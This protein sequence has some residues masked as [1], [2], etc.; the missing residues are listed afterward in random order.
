MKKSQT[1]FWDQD[2]YSWHGRGY[3]PPRDGH[4][5]I[6]VSSNRNLLTNRLWR[7]LETKK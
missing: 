4:L 3:A 5:C 2:R 6:T 7:K 1:V